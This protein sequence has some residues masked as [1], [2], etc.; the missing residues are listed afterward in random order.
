MQ[1]IILAAGIGRR[2]GKITKD[3]PKCMVRINGTPIIENAVKNLLKAGIED[4]VIVVGHGKDVLINFLKERFPKANF[5]F[6][7]NP[8]YSKTNNIYSLYLARDFFGR[9]D[10]ILLESDVMFESEVLERLLSDKREVLAV[11][12]KYKSWMDGTVVKL[13]E[14]DNITA[15]IPQEFFDYKELDEYYKTVNIYKFSAEYMKDVY[16]PFLE[17]Y[18]KVLGRNEYYELVLRVISSLE[19]ANIKALKLQGEKWYEIDTPEDIRNAECV[20]APDPDTKLK[21][22]ISRHGG[23]WRFPYVKD[24]CYLVNPFFP[25]KQ[26]ITQL[27]VNFPT[28]L[29]SYPSTLSVINHTAGAL[30]GVSENHIVVAN[31]ASELIHAISDALPITV[32][33]PL[34]TFNEY[35]EKFRNFIT[36]ETHPYN[37]N[38]G[39]RD[40]LSFSEKTDA[41]LLINPDN[42]SGHYIR[43]ENVLS[44]LQELK[45]RNKLLILDESFVDFADEEGSLIDEETVKEYENLC[46]IKS[47]GKSYGVAGIRLGVLVSSNKEIVRKVRDL[48][49]IWN[50]SS[51]AEFFLQIMDKHRKEYAIACDRLRKERKRLYEKLKEIDFL[52]PLPSQGNFFMCEV[53]PPFT[54]SEL[55]KEMLWR[56]NILIKDLTGKPGIRGEYVRIAVK[57]PEENEELLDA[58]RQL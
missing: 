42:P 1:A 18:I 20:F 26:L 10:T 51:P 33:V 57:T 44:L 40:L 15:F 56:F 7:E 9:D 3:I 39:I 17:A 53:L 14:E 34:P 50:I 28:L 41:L 46:I 47:L 31:G 27:Q 35:I 2:L 48:L 43:K 36:L 32:G 54:A 22:L 12:D 58:I 45:K 23:F 11:V 37:Y 16:L 52:E 49:P 29:S 8:E 25:H 38:Y 55:T 6:V 5:E 4:I 24:F 21:C 19:R 30:F 13:D